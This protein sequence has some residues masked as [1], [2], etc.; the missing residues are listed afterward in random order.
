MCKV[1]T[2]SDIIDLLSIAHRRASMRRPSLFIL[3]V[4][5]LYDQISY[6]NLPLASNGKYDCLIEVGHRVKNWFAS[7]HL[8]KKKV[9][10][11]NSE[12]SLSWNGWFRFK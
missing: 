8:I 7:L 1:P 4:V 3:I 11:L 2:L 6:V 5:G 12:Y 10:R 9:L